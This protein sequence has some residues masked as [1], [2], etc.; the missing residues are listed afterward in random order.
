MC[1]KPTL[2]ILALNDK[3]CNNSG[4]KSLGCSGVVSLGACYNQCKSKTEPCPGDPLLNCSAC[5]A[6]TWASGS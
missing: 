6:M 3:K 1:E 2:P 4:V 5:S